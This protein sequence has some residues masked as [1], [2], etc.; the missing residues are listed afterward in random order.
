MKNWEELGGEFGGDGESW[1][2]LGDVGKGVLLF[3]MFLVKF[4][5]QEWGVSPF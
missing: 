2:E 5:R 4:T 3:L 1:E